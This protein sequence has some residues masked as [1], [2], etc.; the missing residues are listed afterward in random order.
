MFRYERPQKGRSRQFHQ[1]T[2]EVI[3]SQAVSQDV[4]LILLLDRYFRTVLKIEN[5]ALIIN[6]LGCSDDREKHRTTLRAFLDKADVK[7]Q[8][9]GFCSER[10]HK[11][12]LRIF[13]CKNE[14]CHRVY[15]AAPM[16]TH[17]L[18]SGCTEEW[19][20]VQEQ[21]HLLSVSYIHKP[22]LVRGLDYYNKT[23][24]EFVSDDLGAQNAFCGGGRYDSLARMIGSEQDYP[25]IG[26]AFGIDRLML[27]LEKN[28]DLIV[29]QK[30]NNK[31]MI[32][33]LD[34][35][36]YTLA[37]LVADELRAL[38][39]W[40]VDLCL[41]GASI[42]SMMRR[43]NKQDVRYALIIGEDERVSRTV[44]IK[45]MVTGNQ[46][47]VAQKDIASYLV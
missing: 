28:K 29:Q 2:I 44:V 46:E 32:M 31:V 18:C 15:Q 24:F 35:Q 41:E 8:I 21:L 9:C 45:D 20:M 10:M 22:T 30:N 17:H 7:E 26:A 12:I 16:I 38:G 40:S 3:G 13:D 25:S 42:K 37:L 5:F 6:S 34:K 39:K 11:N 47:R 4:E 19:T 23:V 27:L 36:L 33:P 1:V 43:A 14:A